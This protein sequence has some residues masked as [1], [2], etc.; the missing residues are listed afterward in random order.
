MKV[1]IDS[2][3]STDRLLNNGNI[4]EGMDDATARLGAEIHLVE[5]RT[6]CLP[7]LPGIIGMTTERML[8]VGALTRNNLKF[9]IT[10]TDKLDLTFA[11]AAWEITDVELVCEYEMINDAVARALEAM[12]PNGIRIPFTAFSLQSISV[13]ADVSSITMLLSHNFCSVKTFFTI[14]RLDSKKTHPRLNM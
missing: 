1:L 10:L 6:Y 4:L 8:P 11:L 5:S 3:A 9:F 12:N 7:I 2:Q 13:P 14:F